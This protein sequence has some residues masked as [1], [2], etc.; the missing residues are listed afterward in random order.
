MSVQ[1]Q[2]INKRLLE[3]ELWK[4]SELATTAE[5]RSRT[6]KT[7]DGKTRIIKGR[8]A[9]LGVLCMGESTIWEKVRKGDMP[10]PLKLSDRVRAWRTTDLIE[11]LESKQ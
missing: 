8:P 7:K 9:R 5:R 6:Y 10:S 1:N 3:R 2:F 4:I 11:W